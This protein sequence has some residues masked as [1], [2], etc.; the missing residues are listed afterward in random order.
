MV[1]VFHETFVSVMFVHSTVII[2][3]AFIF[4]NSLTEV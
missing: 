4:L 2:E 1:R 3:N